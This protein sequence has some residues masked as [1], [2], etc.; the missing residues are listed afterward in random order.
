MPGTLASV[1]FLVDLGS[2]GVNKSPG[3]HLPDIS[4]SRCVP[5]DA[6]VIAGC[7]LNARE[8][9]TTAAGQVDR[10][11]PV[12]LD[13]RTGCD[14]GIDHRTVDVGRND[15]GHQLGWRGMCLDES[16]GVIVGGVRLDPPGVP[17]P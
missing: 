9:E 10:D 2:S 13:V 8:V 4:A 14:Y 11:I 6:D 7:V 15:Q 17:I 3:P 1:A 16:A 5:R 12:L